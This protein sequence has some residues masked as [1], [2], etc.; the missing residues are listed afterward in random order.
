MFHD[1]RQFNVMKYDM[2]AGMAQHMKGGSWVLCAGFQFGNILL[3]NDS[4]NEDSLQEYAAFEVLEEHSDEGYIV[5]R[6]FESLT[7]S[8]IEVEK[9]VDYLVCYAEEIPL[10]F[11]GQP[12]KLSVDYI[13]IHKHYC[14]LCA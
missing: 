11:L 9:L 3:I 1:K 2:A 12:Q 14:Q 10:D 7:V 4:F 13:G 5:A 8:W 6:Q